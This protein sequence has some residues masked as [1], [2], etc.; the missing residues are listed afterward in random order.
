ML[1][2]NYLILS[3][4]IKVSPCINTKET[5]CKTILIQAINLELT[6]ALMRDCCSK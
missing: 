2:I 1:E 5:Y 6:K 3:Y 4:L